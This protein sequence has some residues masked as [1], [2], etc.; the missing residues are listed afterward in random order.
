MHPLI[1][2]VR[3]TIR[4]YKML[5]PGEKVVVAVSGGPDSMALLH[6]LWEIR[7][8]LG[9]SLVAT[10]LNH[11]LRP[12]AG[13]EKSFVHNVATRL[14]IPF[15]W[16][17]ADVRGRQKARNLSLQ[18]AAREIRYEFLLAASRKYGATKIALGHTA[19]DQA[20]SLIMRFLRGAGTRG[21]AGIPPKRD[22]IFIRP[23]IRTWKTEIVSYLQERK[24]NFLSDPSN[25]SLQY[26]RNRVRHELLPILE[27]YNPRIRQTL[28]QMAELSRE[29]EDF[30]QGLL[31]KEFPLLLVGKREKNRLTLD[32]PALQVHPVALRFRIYRKGIEHLAGNLRSMEFPHFLAID[33]LL[34]NPGPSKQIRLPHG[35]SVSR[36][37]HSLIFFNTPAAPVSFE[38]SVSGPGILEIPE[39]GG[40]M[41]FAMIPAQ[42]RDPRSEKPN[43]ALLDFDSIDFPLTVRS[44]RPGDRFQPLGME[45]EKKVK[46]LFMDCKI[47]V[48]RRKKIPLLL[49]KDCLLWVVGVRVDHR[50]RLKPRTRR[51]LKVEFH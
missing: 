39:I 49:A 21:L 10:H 34:E 48:E 17:K 16:K 4:R 26:L 8:D 5:Q 37:Y 30:W 41:R 36:S 47:P 24:I 7:E 27:R 44:F 3:R 19:D 12:E 22:E 1:L 28:V 51:A 6:I 50:A 25:R 32:I 42:G 40:T 45:G 43:L 31:E 15:H 46:D 20:E 29:E 13:K 11:G 9:I 2:K 35:I 33:H 14:G 38:Y 23:L 18:E